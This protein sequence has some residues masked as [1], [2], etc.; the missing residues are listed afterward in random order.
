MVVDAY[1]VTRN[2]GRVYMATLSSIIL[3]SRSPGFHRAVLYV[4]MDPA[5]PFHQGVAM[6]VVDMG[7]ATVPVGIVVMIEADRETDFGSP[8]APVEVP[9]PLPAFVEAPARGPVIRA[10]IVI[11]VDVGAC[12]AGIPVIIKVAIDDLD[13]RFFFE[14]I[15]ADGFH[16]DDVAPLS[17]D[18]QF[19]LAVL[20]VAV[21]RDVYG[22]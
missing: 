8:V 21:R 2:R 13:L 9:G 4:V 16:V 7:V 6:A 3:F 5:S 20:K 12:G 1:T 11:V 15:Y 19:E 17:D 10:A 22:F 14:K 18:V